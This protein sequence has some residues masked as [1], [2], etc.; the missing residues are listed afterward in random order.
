MSKN[1]VERNNVEIE[2][3]VEHQLSV[4]ECH[5]H[6]PCGIMFTGIQAQNSLSTVCTPKYEY[7][8]PD[9]FT[10]PSPWQPLTN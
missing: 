9:V 10:S 7:F 2:K 8:T 6:N 3:S 5:T 1:L 4:V